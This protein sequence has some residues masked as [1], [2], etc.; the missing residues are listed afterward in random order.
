M[1]VLVDVDAYAMKICGRRQKDID[2]PTATTGQGSHEEYR[3]KWSWIWSELIMSGV[4]SV[5]KQ[6]HWRRTLRLLFA[7]FWGNYNFLKLYLM[8]REYF[9]FCSLANRKEIP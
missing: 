7:Q 6:M 2:D 5:P 9:T 4:L 8:G 3:S 1:L